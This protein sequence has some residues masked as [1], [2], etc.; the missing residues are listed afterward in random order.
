MTTHFTNPCLLYGILRMLI[1]LLDIS[2]AGTGNKK[3]KFTE[4]DVEKFQPRPRLNQ[5]VSVTY[6]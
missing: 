4:T 1:L 3:K 2:Q 5:E 6:I